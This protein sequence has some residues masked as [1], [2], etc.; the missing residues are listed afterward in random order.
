MSEK[1][2]VL[3]ISGM[4]CGSCVA[5][6][7]NAFKGV[8]GINKVAIDL[9]NKKAKFKLNEDNIIS[10]EEIIN[11]IEKNGFKASIAS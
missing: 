7:E 4:S 2:I 11:I 6:I 3:N 10:N 5:K 9:P 8:D 1:K